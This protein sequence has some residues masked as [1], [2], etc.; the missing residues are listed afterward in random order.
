MTML[1]ERNEIVSSTE[2]VKNFPRYRNMAKEKTRMFIFKNNKP[3]LALVDIDVYENLLKIAELV[4]SQE[5]LAMIEE[6]D[7]LDDG[8]RYSVADVKRR[9]AIKKSGLM[10]A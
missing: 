10:Q 1:M 2:L 9:R 7:K 8:K 3:D 5:I 4:E 6:R